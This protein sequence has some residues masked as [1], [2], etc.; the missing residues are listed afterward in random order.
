MFAVQV[1]PTLSVWLLAPTLIIWL[2]AEG[3]QRTLPPSLAFAVVD[4]IAH[5]SV[6]LLCALALAPTWGFGPVLF[7]LAAATLIDA[8]HALAAG[9]L[10][11]AQ[12]MM[13]GARPATHSLC[14]AV[15][16]ALL[17]GAA[18]NYRDAYGTL[19]GAVTHIVRDAVATPGVPLFA[20]FSSQAHVILPEWTLPAVM[21]T[22]GLGGV[23]LAHAGRSMAVLQKLRFS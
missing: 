20:P 3:V 21:L 1:R 8:D 12:M 17:I 22:F 4:E 16:L 6:A 15:L 9:S 13:L 7:A 18:T 10:D 14:G 23:F 5:A 11:P 2:I 19:L